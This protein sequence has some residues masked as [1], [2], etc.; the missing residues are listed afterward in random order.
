MPI[1]GLSARQSVKLAAIVFILAV[2]LIISLTVYYIHKKETYENLYDS[3]IISTSRKYN[4]DPNLI[5]AV[6]WKESD[7]NPFVIGTKKERGLM[8]IMEKHAAQDWANYNKCPVPPPGILYSPEINISIGTWYLSRCLSHWSNYKDSLA[9][10]IAEYN[11]GYKNAKEWA[12]QNTQESVIE[13]IT[14]PSTKKYVISILK[15]Y[16]T[17]QIS[18]SSLKN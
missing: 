17:Y 11:A 5:K 2:L 10:A 16:R 3:I 4:V 18:G 13:N 1:L 14:F 7:F 6:I 12:P 8:Q 9:L 15:K